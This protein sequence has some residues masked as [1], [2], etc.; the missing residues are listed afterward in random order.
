MSIEEKIRDCEF[1]LKQINH[2]NPD[3]YYVDYFF[4]AYI[5]FVI[6]VYYKIF[7]EAN[8]GFGLFVSGK[9]TKEKFE[10]KAKEK[11]DHL[12]L[13]FLSWFEENY[14]KEHNGSY[15]NFIQET[16]YFFKQYNHLP[17]IIIK[18]R[19]N[20][21]YKDDFFQSIQVGLTKGKIRSKKELEIEI[22]RQMPV[23]LEIINQ[24]RKSR[25]EPKIS[26]NQIIASAYLEMENYE[27]M[28]ISHACEVYLPVM[29]RILD[30]SR[31]EIKQLTSWNG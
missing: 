7:E 30:E 24:K 26:K 13:K 19:P 11:D 23:Y 27:N 2:F 17:K 6:D 16:I 4:K 31:K 28:E 12:A 20:Q 3:P 29:R 25:S 5:Q 10:K 15:P 21:R 14:K 1:N 9:C 8:G 22:K 18:I